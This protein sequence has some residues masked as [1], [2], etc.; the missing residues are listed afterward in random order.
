MAYYCTML[1]KIGMVV[2]EHDVKTNKL[3]E[4]YCAQCMMSKHKVK[5]LLRNTHDV[6]QLCM[7][8]ICS[9]C[10]EKHCG[11]EG[12]HLDVK[13]IKYKGDIAPYKFLEKSVAELI[14]KR[15]WV[16]VPFS[17]FNEVKI[18]AWAAF[19][20]SFI[21]NTITIVGC[22]QGDES[23]YI[24]KDTYCKNIV[25]MVLVTAQETCLPIE[26]NCA[27]DFKLCNNASMPN[28]HAS[29]TTLQSATNLQFL[30]DCM[31]KQKRCATVYHMTQLL[32]L[33]KQTQMHINLAIETAVS[34]G[35]FAV[36]DCTRDDLTDH[37]QLC[38]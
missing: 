18:A 9:A 36:L 28:G 22:L 11:P 16:D 8:G 34:D 37:I 26:D 15:K 2:P 20:W 35:Y 10:K 17:E 29:A 27:W 14:D 6:C 31:L 5:T 3:C 24:S 32:T 23:M 38:Y 33:S 1:K 30:L 25:Q 21:D 13:R 19:T 7:Y 12:H 4:R